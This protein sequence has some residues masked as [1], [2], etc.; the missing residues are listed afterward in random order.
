MNTPFKPW[1]AGV[2]AA[3]INHLLEQQP[4]ARA[5]F[6]EYHGAVFR[7]APTGPKGTAALTGATGSSGQIFD[8]LITDFTILED[9][10]LSPG[11]V[12]PPRVTLQFELSPNLALDFLR[13]GSAGAMRR[14]RIE[15]DAALATAIAGLARQLRWDVEEDLSHVIGDLA[16]HRV[17]ETVRSAAAGGRDLM[18]RART[19]TLQ[20]L[21]HDDGALVGRPALESFR[22]D[23]R[24]LRDD[25]ERLAKRVERLDR[26][27]RPDRLDRLQQSAH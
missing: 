12:E 18:D 14:V 20:W 26:P 17:G 8:R 9:G 2:V 7:I 19:T 6:A 11:A 24:R 15:G 21:I 3:A 22:D 10:R 1:G 5:S 25:V 4:S 16:A 27:D 13:D 23:L